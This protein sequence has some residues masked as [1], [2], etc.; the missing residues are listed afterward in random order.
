MPHMTACPIL[1]LGNLSQ[2][3]IIL[4]TIMA[5]ITAMI[6]LCD[7]ISSPQP[8]SLKGGWRMHEKYAAQW[9]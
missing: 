6:I 8:D 7:P 1:V 4:Y 3:L 2:L 9:I 5:V